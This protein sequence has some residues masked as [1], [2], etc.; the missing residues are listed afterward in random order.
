MADVKKSKI[1]K[2]LRI[3]WPVVAILLFA[4]ILGQ[5][6]MMHA[7]SS[8]RDCIYMGPHNGELPTD[9]GYILP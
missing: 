5:L 9:I 8:E 4:I 2:F 1:L 3:N 7:I 6:L